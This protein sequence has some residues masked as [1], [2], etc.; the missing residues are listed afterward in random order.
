MLTGHPPFRGSHSEAIGY[1][2]RNEPATPI[3]AERPE[4]PEEVEQLVFRALHKEAGVRYPSGRELARALR[5]VRGLSVPT[6][7]RTAPVTISAAAA[8]H[9]PRR[10][11]RRR[12]AAAL[13]VLI[14]AVAT[15]TLWPVERTTM[16]ITPFGNQTGDSE[17]E[18]FRPALTQLLTLSLRDSS[19]LNVVPFN[20]VLESVRRFMRDGADISNRDAVQAVPARTD[21]T[22]LIVP[23]LLRDGT[24]W[25]A[26]V[27]LRDARTANNLWQYETAPVTSS[28]THDTA[29]QLTLALAT[30]VNRRVTPLRRR[31][32]DTVKAL[33]PVGRRAVA[34]P[35]SLEAAKAFADGVA[36]YDD[37]EYARARQRFADAV[38]LDPQNPLLLAWLSRTA[39]II[40][41]DKT[42]TDAG[43][44]AV[45][46]ITARTA[47]VDALFAQ[48][49]ASEA[50]RDAVA[51]EDAYRS[52]TVVRPDD[53]TW[54]TELAGFLD[55]QGKPADAVSAYHAALGVNARLLRPRLELCRLY[56]PSRLNEP[57]E[58]KK[59][60]Q[61]AVDGYRAI[62]AMGGE[63]QSLLCLTDTLAVGND[64]DRAQA[65][66]YAEMAKS[67][68]GQLRYEY[69]EARAE[70]YLAIMAGKREAYAQSID[71]GERALAR[72][73][74][75]GNSPVQPI[76]M[77]NLGIAHVALG[78]RDKAAEYYR[79]AYTLYQSWHDESRAARIQANR[80]A[81]L[82]EYGNP[83]EGVLDV[84][85]ALSVS[86]K[87]KDRN[88][89]TFCLRVIATYYRN[90]GRHTD[91]ITELNKGLA[92]A[93]ER[94]LAENVTMM[95]TFLALSQFEMGDYDGARQ[96]LVNAL[97]DGTGRGSTEARIRLARAYVR[98]GDVSAAAGELETAE[99][100]IQKSPNK[101][102]QALLSL[103]RG[104][105]A[106]EL[107]TR[108]EARTSFEQ[109][110]ALWGDGVPE[111]AA[112]EARA[113][114]GYLEARAGRVDRGR[115]RLQSALDAARRLGQLSIEVRSLLLLA[116]LAIDRGRLM[117]ASDLLD[118]VPEDQGGRTIGPE[119]RAQTYM[120]Q[121]RVQAA[122]G[123]L[124]AA[125]TNV[126]SARERIRAIV[127]RLPEQYRPLF[128]GR[129]TV[130]QIL[131]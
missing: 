70:Y 130:R 37:L 72:A 97:K 105:R 108:D 39:Q 107:R 61:A 131:D 5:H 87:L 115:E 86:E 38:E 7:L 56:S 58:A 35:R 3:R 9:R 118:A 19:A 49:V 93:R 15:W 117:E 125:K 52:L 96:S 13:A 124:E 78:N 54:T 29:Y 59:H 106:Y 14:A 8:R 27:E 111:P 33:G 76:I 110:S 104:E 48:A 53:L 99:R 12:I 103:V 20:A 88:F 34:R 113:Y 85:N 18:Q 90:Q 128:E 98:L 122:R 21:A 81:M 2:V 41:D 112:V 63:G 82:I 127:E 16:A 32:L 120:M 11:T 30:E 74:Q 77:N 80:G 69:N 64:A 92:I 114:A 31:V 71:I 50:R 62:G 65:Q 91:A 42:A 83:E 26:R 101:P 40:R 126:A 121:S 57:A 84:K 95:T 28:L 51:A 55:R 100:D 47:R 66:S 22:V 68:F 4:V 123:E 43:E 24:A 79:Q 67:V 94:N 45:A 44:R 60:G 10:G 23:T 89:E 102:L 75:A 129:Q 116:D 73:R 109:A 1:A 25:R 119:L 36:W 6:E 46:A 17:L